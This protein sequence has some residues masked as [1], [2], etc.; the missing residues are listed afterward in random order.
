MRKN[1]VLAFG[2]SQ[3]LNFITLAACAQIDSAVYHQIKNDKRIL[4]IHYAQVLF[5]NGKVKEEGWEYKKENNRTDGKHWGE[6]Y[7]KFPVIIFRV[8][9][10]KEYYKNGNLK[11]LGNI[12]LEEDST[13]N[14]KHFNRKGE[15]VYEFYFSG[16]EEKDYKLTEKGRRRKLKNYK[17]KEYR[18]GKLWLEEGYR[19]GKKDGEWKEYIKEGQ[20]IITEYNEGK[21][22]KR[23][24]SSARF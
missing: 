11:M 12:P 18:K 21:K 19:N 3:V 15:L 1:I 9:V 10:W 2:L 23:T 6:Q 13:R 17:K 22:V 5:K 4:G 14:E 7:D 20:T 24:K 16:K 8:G